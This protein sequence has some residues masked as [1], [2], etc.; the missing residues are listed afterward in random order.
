[1]R[2]SKEIGALVSNHAATTACGVT[3][4]RLL[5]DIL[6]LW[7]TGTEPLPQ[8][9][10][11]LRPVPFVKSAQIVDCFLRQTLGN[12]QRIDG[13]VTLHALNS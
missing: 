4:K 1:M 5:R 11:Q 3:Q 6:R 9:T 13:T 10:T 12:G 8:V 2:N 7:G